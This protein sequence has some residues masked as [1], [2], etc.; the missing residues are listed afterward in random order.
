M[1]LD[2]KRIAALRDQID[3]HERILSGECQ[4]SESFKPYLDK[5]SAE[6]AL[7]KIE[8]AGGLA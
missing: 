3:T 7:M 8:L 6:L 1:K 2:L 4:F 5:I